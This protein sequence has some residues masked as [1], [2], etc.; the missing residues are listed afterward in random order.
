MPQGAILQNNKMK[1]QTCY[2]Y[3]LAGQSSTPATCA[4]Q[5]HH[6]SWP[7][8]PPLAWSPSPSGGSHHSQVIMMMLIIVMMRATKSQFDQDGN[9]TLV[10]NDRAQSTL[11][12]ITY[13]SGGLEFTPGST[14]YLLSIRDSASNDTECERNLKLLLMVGATVDHVEEKPQNFEAAAMLSVNKPRRQLQRR[15]VQEEAV[16]EKV[17]IQQFG[18]SPSSSSSRQFEESRS[19]LSESDGRIPAKL[20]SSSCVHRGPCF[21]LVIFL[22]LFL[23]LPWPNDRA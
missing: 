17:L 14:H 3:K 7:T 18:F 1:L 21:S 4:S 8:A 15:L 13:M 10:N 6:V 16:K 11:P 9:V 22:A 19:R 23:I 5:P 2:S 12:I 20:V